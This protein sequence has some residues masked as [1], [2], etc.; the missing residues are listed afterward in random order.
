MNT[1][2]KR[3]DVKKTAKKITDLTNTVQRPVK[4]IE[5]KDE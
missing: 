2:L 3:K 1:S 5:K 4:L